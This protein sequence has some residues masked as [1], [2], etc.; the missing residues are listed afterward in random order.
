MYNTLAGGE[1]DTIH[2]VINVLSLSINLVGA[3]ITVWG[4]L[5]S[6][7]SFIHKEVF[8]RKKA[9]ELNETIRLK[10]GSYLV[11]ALEFFIASDIVKTIITPTWETLGMLGAIIVI[12]TVLSYFL[13][14]DVSKK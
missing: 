10:L 4:I 12:R 5:L 3:S 11:L 6:L 1:M 7:L 2:D 13:T 14:K 8:N 9:I